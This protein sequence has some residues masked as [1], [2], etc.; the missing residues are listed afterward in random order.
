[1]SFLVFL[2]RIGTMNLIMRRHVGRSVARNPLKGLHH[3]RAIREH[4]KGRKPDATLSELG[5]SG[6]LSQGSSFLATL[7]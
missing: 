6:A 7:V 5:C 4:A 3:T 1:V 2:T